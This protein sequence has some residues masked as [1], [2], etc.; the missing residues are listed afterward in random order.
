MIKNFLR[1][2]RVLMTLATVVLSE[3]KQTLRLSRCYLLHLSYDRNSLTDR[4]FFI[5]DLKFL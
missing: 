3:V 5:K 1:I 2:E 4:K